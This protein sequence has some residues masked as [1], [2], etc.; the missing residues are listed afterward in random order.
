MNK[1][2]LAIT[3]AIVSTIIIGVVGNIIIKYKYRYY[4]SV[5]GSNYNV[6][7]LLLKGYE[8]YVIMCDDCLLD[9]VRG[10]E[11]KKKEKEKDNDRP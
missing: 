11:D 5:C 10:V 3:I 9:R 2:L 8:D 7:E 6:M 1:I 4:C